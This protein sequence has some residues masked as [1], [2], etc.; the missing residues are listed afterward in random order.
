MTSDRAPVLTLIIATLLLGTMGIGAGTGS[1]SQRPAGEKDDAKSQSLFDGKNLGH[2]KATDF[3]GQGEVKV[4]DGNLLL[5]HGETL[6]GVTWQGDPPAKMNYEIDLDAQRVDGSDFFCGLTF[7]VNKDC[8][9]LIVG[10]WGGGLCGIS[11]LGGDDAANN[12]T[13]SI[14]QFKKGKWYHI[15]LRVVPDKIQAWVDDEKIVD[16]NTKGQKISVRSEVDAS[17]P[18]GLA[19]Y[20]T[21]AA[22]KN[23][24]MRKLEAGGK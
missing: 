1:N 2:W 12:N 24:T 22:I 11:C 14:H 19:S 15:R 21:T 13:T 20:Q 10:G 4:D 5:T 3:G 9:S 8:A 16:V 23:I 6:T 7:P 17:Q 18:L